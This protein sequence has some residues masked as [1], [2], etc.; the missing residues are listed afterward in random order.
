MTTKIKTPDCE[1]CVFAKHNEEDDSWGR[2]SNDAC[3]SCARNPYAALKDNYKKKTKVGKNDK[4][5]NKQNK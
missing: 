3:R 5:N 1:E 2:S 4:G